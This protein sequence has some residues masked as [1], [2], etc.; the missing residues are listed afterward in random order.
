MPFR[1]V[2]VVR[3]GGAKRRD[4]IHFIEFVLLR[5]VQP[6]GL[7]CRWKTGSRCV[8][9]MCKQVK[10]RRGECT[11]EIFL[12]EQK[13]FEVSPQNTSESERTHFPK[14]GTEGPMFSASVVS[15][16]EAFAPPARRPKLHSGQVRVQ[17]FQRI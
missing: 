5:P 3:G 14:S 13:T 11:A 7:V 8:K 15:C 16:G 4:T 9:P 12:S 17:P 1:K 6:F 10:R 2:S